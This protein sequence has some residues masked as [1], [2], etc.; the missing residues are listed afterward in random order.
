MAADGG[1]RLGVGLRRP[2]AG[3]GGAGRGRP[4]SAAAADVA[5]GGFGR[6]LVAADVGSW[7]RTAAADLVQDCGGR[8]LVTVVRVGG[9]HN[10][11]R[12]PTWPLSVAAASWWRRA[13]P[14]GGGRRPPSWCKTS[15]AASW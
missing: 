15:A 6:Q 10:R 3:D 9:G 7:Q 8:N 11:R 2:Q 13:S 12:P 4:Q 14:H 1:R 5:F